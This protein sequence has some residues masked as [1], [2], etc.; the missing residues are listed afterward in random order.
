MYIGSIPGMAAVLTALLAVVLLFPAPGL[1]EDHGNQIRTLESGARR[2]LIEVITTD[3]R[4]E[5]PTEETGGYSRLR[6]PGLGLTAQGG[7]PALPAAGFLVGIPTEGKPTV[8]VLEQEWISLN[9]DPLQPL[10]TP[11]GQPSP[12]Q[13][14]VDWDFIADPQIYGRDAFFPGV[15]AEIEP[16]GLFRDQRI[17]RVRVQ[18]FHY[19]P[20]KGQLKVC[21]RL[22]VQVDFPTQSSPRPGTDLLQSISPA[23]ERVLSAMLINY[24][25]ARSWRQERAAEN[26]PQTG[27]L[28]ENA[29]IC[30]INVSENGLHSI[31][32]QELRDA[33]LNLSNIDPR[34]FQLT[35]K[36]R[37]VP[38]YI[39]GEKD[40]SFDEADAIEFYGQTNTGTYLTEHEDMY[41]DPYDDRN[42][43]WLSWGLSPGLRMVEEDGGIQAVEP[44]KPICYQQ[45][46]H[47]EENNYR[48]HLNKQL[49]VRDHWFWDSGVS[50]Q[51]LKSYP[52]H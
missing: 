36:G 9:T 37:A 44:R 2:A 23:A 24:T 45:T 38:I 42:V 41:Q 27:G 52:L 16:L 14:R 28:L 46:V 1:S 6:A 32:P 49:E 18:P 8:R 15:V 31:H 7:Q 48:D 19:N 51:Q 17:A 33:G 20:V 13:R 30:K 21:Q 25:Q 10:P 26:L 22:V 29:P 3:Y 39:I 5:P 12:D 43:Y 4:V 35:N 47:A 11:Q 40:G 50:A 34:T